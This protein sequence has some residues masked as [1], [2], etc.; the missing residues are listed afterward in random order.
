MTEGF[1]RTGYDPVLFDL[2]G[3]VVDTVEL[4]RASF[5]HA[6]RTV[7]GTVLPDE[8]I[9]RFVGQ[10]L[11]DQMRQ[12]SARHAQE[13]YDVYRE[14]NH[15]VH[16]ELIRGY[17]GVEEMLAA[18]RRHGRRLGLVTSKSTKP[19][20]MAFRALD[21]EHHFDAVITADDTET[22]KPAPEPLLLCLRRLAALGAPD[23]PAGAIYVGDSPFDIRAG[24]AAGM[25]TAAVT[26]GIFSRA[27]LEAARPSY[28]LERPGDVMRVCLEGDAEG[29][30]SPA[31]GQPRDTSRESAG[32]S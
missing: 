2:D 32:H 23:D 3:T 22:H 30:A 6:T 16:D 7:L 27:A 25:A 15:R 18:L 11:M 20:A 12:L 29:L 4:I 1:R 17:E 9:M 21:L 31:G 13:L 24:H 19:T 5:R 8:Q 10:P 26:W 14:H 28:V